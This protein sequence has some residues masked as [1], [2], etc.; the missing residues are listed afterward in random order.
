MNDIAEPNLKGLV[1]EILSGAYLLALGI[2]DAEG[3]WV[4]SVIFVH[5]AD[6]NIYWLSTD[7]ARHTKALMADPHAAGSIVAEFKKKQERALQIAGIVEKVEGPLF[8][9]EKALRAKEASVL[10]VFAGET[11]SSHSWYKLTP[12][13][14]EVIYNEHFGW[15]RK[16]F[17]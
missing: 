11:T 1:Q 5:D 13:R 3:P 15:D 9:Q 10:P 16:R 4:S 2:A 6:F 8:E 12:S 7:N 17:L 14:I